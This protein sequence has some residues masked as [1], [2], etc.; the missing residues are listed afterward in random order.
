[1]F[2]LIAKGKTEW[3]EKK[4]TVGRKL[5]GPEE[6]YFLFKDRYFQRMDSLLAGEPTCTEAPNL[7]LG[8]PA[9]WRKTT[10]FRNK[11]GCFTGGMAIIE[12]R[13]AL[14]KKLP[15]KGTTFFRL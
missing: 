15:S 2:S 10:T 14:G 4:T 9:L 11:D 1:M 7:E 8:M 12:R 6:H 3:K 13:M 5:L